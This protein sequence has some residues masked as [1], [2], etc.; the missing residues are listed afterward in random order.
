MSIFWEVV[1]SAGKQWVGASGSLRKSDTAIKNMTGFDPRHLHPTI[2]RAMSAAIKEE[3]QYF[4]QIGDP[5]TD[6]EVT[7]LKL[8]QLSEIASDALDSKQA[9]S[10]D[11]AVSRVKALSPNKIRPEIALRAGLHSGV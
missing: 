7:L 2:Y 8:S 4:F 5:L 6:E 10:F 1:K 11:N 3:Y 9:A